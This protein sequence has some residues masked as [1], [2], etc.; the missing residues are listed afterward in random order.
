MV[1]ISDGDPGDYA[2][3]VR[4]AKAMRSKGVDPIEADDPVAPVTRHEHETTE[5]EM[6][7]EEKRAHD[8]ALEAM[9]AQ[10]KL[11]SDIKGKTVRAQLTPQIEALLAEEKAA[12]QAVTDTAHDIAT[13]ELTLAEEGADTIKADAADTVINEWEVEQSA[14]TPSRDGKEEEPHTR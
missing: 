10:E 8:E 1:R 2:D 5:R 12:K 7:E 14:T 3:R 13:D 6:T 4:K 11:L 9:L